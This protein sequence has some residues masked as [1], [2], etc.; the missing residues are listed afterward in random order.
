M[1]KQRQETE[2]DKASEEEIKKLKDELAN[3]KNQKK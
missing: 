1:S 3:Y 2:K